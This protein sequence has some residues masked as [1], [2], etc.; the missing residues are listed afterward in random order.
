MNQQ[1]QSMGAG[2]MAN[3]ALGKIEG[4]AVPSQQMNADSN[5]SIPDYGTTADMEH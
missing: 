5:S 2:M 1:Q 3:P 4:L